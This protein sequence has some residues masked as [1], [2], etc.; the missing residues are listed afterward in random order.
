MVQLRL[1]T[2]PALKAR[3]GPTFREASFADFEQIAALATRHGLARPSSQEAWRH[4]WLANP[5]YREREGNWTI[6]WVL[7]NDAGRIVASI[8]NIPL[9]YQFQGKRVLAASGRSWVADEEYRSASLLLLEHVITQPTVDLYVNSTFSAVSMPAI[10]LFGC[11]RVPVGVWDESAFWVTDHAAFV[12]SVLKRR[13]NPL[14]TAL[15]YPLSAAL[16]LRERVTRTAAPAGDVEVRSC[17]NFDERFDDFWVAM[18]RR[19][20]NLLLAVRTR[21]VLAWHFKYALAENRAWIATISEGARLIAYAVFDRRYRKDI[22]LQQMRMVDFQAL[23]G[24]S[25]LLPPIIGWALRKCS[26]EGIRMLET[27]GRW[28][29]RGECLNVIAPYR[30]KLSWGW[31]P[32]YRANNARLA[33]DLRNRHSWA[34]S[35]FDGDASLT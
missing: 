7:E 5:H 35:L 25:E 31:P 12:K 10:T 16:L 27:V 30:R 34:P 18:R 14:A 9:A 8:E 13:G 21:E 23:D 24:G 1:S 3:R 26:A 2:T 22:D 17:A 6:G 29:E 33:A 19:H 15:S 32:V 28:L 11:S 20:P 4:L